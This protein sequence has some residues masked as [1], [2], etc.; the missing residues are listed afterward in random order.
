MITILQKKRNCIELIMFTHCGRVLLG[1]LMLAMRMVV[2]GCVMACRGL[3][4]ML[5][6]RVFVLFWHRAFTCKPILPR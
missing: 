3:V 4:M 5:N 6:R 2:R 1:L